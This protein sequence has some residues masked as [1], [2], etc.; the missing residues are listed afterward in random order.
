MTEVIERETEGESETET[1]R[2]GEL[3]TT[4][5]GQR[6]TSNGQRRTGN[7]RRSIIGGYFLKEGLRKACSAGLRLSFPAILRH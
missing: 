5:D 4:E 7:E 6:E 1:E 2:E 3:R